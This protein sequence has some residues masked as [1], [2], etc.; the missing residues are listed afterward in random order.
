MKRLLAFILVVCLMFTTVPALPVTAQ[1]TGAAADTGD[2]SLEGTSSLGNLLTEEV[3]AQQEQTAQEYA[4]YSDSYCVLDLTFQGNVATVEY[5]TL[6]EAVLVVALYTEDGVQLITSGK[7][8]V[9]PELSEATVTIASDMPEYFTASAYLLDVYDS[10]PLCPSYFTPMYTQEMQALLDSTAED[11]D[12][13]LVLKLDEDS[14]TN[15][16]VYNE[17]VIVIPVQEGVN[18]VTSV[19]HD[20]MSYVFENVDENITALEAG[21]VFSYAY[22]D[23]ELLIVKVTSVTTDGTT[24]TIIGGDLEIGEVFTHLKLEQT[25]DAVDVEVDE[26]YADPGIT[27]ME[28]PVT[29]AEEEKIEKEISTSMSIE[30]EIASA[31]DVS[32]SVTGAVSLTLD[33]QIHFYISPSNHFIKFRTEISLEASLTASGSVTFSAKL[34]K[35]AF[36]IY[37][38]GVGFKPKIELTF[39]ASLTLSLG[40]TTT[41]GFSYEKDKG[42]KNL[43]KKPKVT[44]DLTVEGTVFLGLDMH[45]TIDIADGALVELSMT[46][47]IGLELTATPTG[48]VIGPQEPV[49]GT[50]HDCQLCLDMDLHFKREIGIEL[51]FLKCKSLTFGKT[52]RSKKTKICDFY[53][54]FD[55]EEFGKGTCPYQKHQVT[56]SVTDG[57]GLPVWTANVTVTDGEQS[58]TVLPT[59]QYGNTQVFLAP[60]EYTVS[61]T[62]GET[63]V[64]SYPEIE[65]PCKLALKPEMPNTLPDFF[66]SWVEPE[67]VVDHGNVYLSGTCGEDA[68]WSLYRSGLLRISGTGAMTDYAAQGLAPWYESRISVKTIEVEDGITHIGNYAFYHCYNTVS[69]T[70]PDTVTSIGFMSFTSCSALRELELGNSIVSIDGYAFEQC[71]ALKEVDLPATVQNIG[72][73]AFSKCSALTE[74]DI[75]YGVTVIQSTT[76]QECK[77]LTSVTIPETV[78]VI[79]SDAFRSCTAL[80]GMVLPEK[81]TTIG[82]SAFHSCSAMTHINI[83]EAVTSIGSYAFNGCASLT[84]ITVPDGITNIPANLFNGCSS[85]RYVQ[86]PDT[87]TRINT[88]AFQNCTSLI[89]LKLP[90]SLT[91]ID[92]QCFNGCTELT[93]LSFPAALQTIDASA[94]EGCSSLNLLYFA[95]DAPSIHS[96]YG[97]SGVTATAYY[98]ADNTTWTEDKLA[99]YG[100]TI[101]W[102]PYDPALTTVAAEDAFDPAAIPS[103]T[104]IFDGEYST[105]VTEEKIVKTAS[106]TGL[107]PQGEYVL[108]SLVS[109]EVEDPLAADNILYIRQAA[110]DETGYL[111][112]T[113]VQRADVSPSYVMACGPSDQNLS[114]AVITFPT[115]V[116][117]GELQAAAPVVVYEDQVLTEGRDYVVLGNAG[118]TEAGTYS[119]KVRGIYDY[120]GLVSCTYNVHSGITVTQGESCELVTLEQDN[121]LDLV[122]VKDT[123][124]DLNGYD[125]SGTLTL[126]GHKLY[127]MDSSTDRYSC[128]SMGYFNCVDENGDTVIPESHFKG[129]AET[130]GAV[131]R[132]MTI[133]TEKGYTFHRFYLG[134]THS[135]LKPGV[136]G[137]GYKAVFA[138]DEMVQSAVESYGYSL[139]LKGF[140]P[141][142]TENTGCP[143]SGKAITVRIEKFD[144]ETYGETDLTAQV[145]ITVNGETISASPYTTTLK[146]M[147]QAVD[148]NAAA[149]TATQLEAL[150]AWLSKYDITQS[151]DLSNI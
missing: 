123:Y 8:L 97:F 105:E 33:T 11:Y 62:I 14:S 130:I 52:L 150:Q 71:T 58:Y 4:E 47:P 83:P 107:V 98:P 82:Q 29:F 7:T 89:E 56:I 31:G 57:E 102:E 77:S 151:W 93:T 118:F 144:V 95:G 49:D 73:Q 18:T 59:N 64:Y 112:F 20:T 40:A 12:Q 13:S 90:A 81:L 28:T 45:P 137:V 100:G 32:V 63:Q 116:A 66:T 110:A 53:Y 120:S 75:P 94:F 43:S 99:Q 39:S 101:T 141:V 41:L 91:Y 76:F 122:L 129:T 16:G 22:S 128:D 30:K 88:K 61:T 136:G 35:L 138:G 54:Y 37:G 65:E 17:S 119:C 51:K 106:F 124:L 139:Q 147:V 111:C 46:T 145:Y 50:L 142:V 108:L 9:D 19:D 125:L 133:P 60:G 149:Y 114:D 109:L 85:L 36:N 27:V 42:F 87:V 146:D 143:V 1:E 10:T 79:D 104:S 140:D 72:Q 25:E 21:D 15:F 117:D 48:Y 5:S 26:S 70:L 115:M 126:G 2:V 68:T 38:I 113:F 84:Q 6:E 148:A 69:V 135:S 74:I 80:Q 121:T 127:C 23:T 67:E 103:L 3:I 34:P 78:T 55:H 96:S 134:V 44:S 86:L 24:A 131:K 132:Y 92:Y